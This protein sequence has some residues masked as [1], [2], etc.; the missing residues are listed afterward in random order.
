[1]LFWGHFIYMFM[2]NYCGQTVINHSTEIL[3]A[4]YDTLWY[5]A[6]LSIQKL[7]LI[8]LK[9]TKSYSFN[10]GGIFTPSLEGFSTL[11]TSAISYFTVMYTM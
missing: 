2:A 10:I 8:L 4:V 3:Q 11:I 6:P 1:M 5:L 9:S 7:L